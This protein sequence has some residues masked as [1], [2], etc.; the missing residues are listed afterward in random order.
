MFILNLQ[1]TQVYSYILP[2]I[3]NQNLFALPLAIPVPFSWLELF[4]H[5]IHEHLT[6]ADLDFWLVELCQ[7]KGQPEATTYNLP[8]WPQCCSS[9][10]SYFADNSGQLVPTFL[11]KHWQK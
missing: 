7:A 8:I 5:K 3:L 2:S 4:L 9:W 1:P 10:S 6:G 11:S